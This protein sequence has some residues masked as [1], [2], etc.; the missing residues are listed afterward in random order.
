[1]AGKDG[2]FAPLQLRRAALTT[3]PAVQQLAQFLAG[4]FD[5]FVKDA[6]IRLGFDRDEADVICRVAA[7]GAMKSFAS[8]VKQTNFERSWKRH[9]R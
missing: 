5:R 4:D 9:G 8:A 7:G 1:M 3:E 6:A 2:I